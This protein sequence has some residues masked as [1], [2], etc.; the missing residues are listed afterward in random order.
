RSSASS[1]SWVSVLTRTR[2]ATGDRKPAKR[3]SSEVLPAPL[4]PSTASAWPARTR[5]DRLSN[6]LLSP[7]TQARFSAVR[8]EI[9]S[10]FT[11]AGLRAGHPEPQA[12]LLV[13]LDGRVKPGHGEG[14]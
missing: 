3:R 6:S 9:I 2:P 13:A 10:L 5:K 1:L 11:M 7:R 14:C 4:A 12:P 8:E